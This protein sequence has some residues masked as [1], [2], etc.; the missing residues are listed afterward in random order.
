LL[1]YFQHHMDEGRLR[2]MM[3]FVALQAF[4]GPLFIHIL[5]RS[6]AERA[7]GL[8]L[9]IDEVAAQFAALWLR[10]M[11]PERAETRE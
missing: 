5:T 2:P 7:V 10:A 3:P 1:N 8:T 9:S 4:L 6:L 11:Q